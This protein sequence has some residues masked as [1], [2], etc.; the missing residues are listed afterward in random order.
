MLPFISKHSLSEEKAAGETEPLYKAGEY[1][2]GWV[3]ETAPR[4]CL[5]CR[6][7][8]DNGGAHHRLSGVCTR[9]DVSPYAV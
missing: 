9:L 5:Q 8:F 4:P 7:T 2:E 3:R 1:S 6:M